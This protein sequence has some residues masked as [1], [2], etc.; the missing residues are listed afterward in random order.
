MGPLVSFH[1]PG[2]TPAFGLRRA[3]VMKQVAPSIFY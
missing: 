3:K 2:L 1:R